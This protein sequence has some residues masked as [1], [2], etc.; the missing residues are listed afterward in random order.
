[1]TPQ[2]VLLRAFCRVDDELK[3]FGL[4]R[5]ARSQRSGRVRPWIENAIGQLVVRTRAV[6]CASG[7]WHLDRLERKIISHT[8]TTGRNDHVSHK[9]PCINS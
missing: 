5:A 1:M 9:P 2:Y 8:V 6:G 3:A 7:L 4:P